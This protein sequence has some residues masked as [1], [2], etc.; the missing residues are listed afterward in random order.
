MAEAQAVATSS[1]TSEPDYRHLRETILTVLARGDFNLNCDRCFKLQEFGRRLVAKIKVD[2]ENTVATLSECMTT[3]LKILDGILKEASSLRGCAL[4]R[5]R[6]WTKFHQL[7]CTT[8]ALL[9]TEFLHKL[10]VFCTNTLLLQSVTQEIFEGRMKTF[11][12]V[13][14]SLCT[15]L[16][17]EITEDEK[18]IILY[19]CGYVPVALKRRYEKRKGESM[20]HLYSIYY[21]C[22]LVPLKTPFTTM[23]ESGL[24]L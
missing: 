24:K 21:T 15:S 22:L 5:E 12:P 6:T 9:W 10:N 17:E 7:R 16:D 23:Q 18:N 8:I 11:F 13:K 19:V 14:E 3:L 20:L 4:Q 2:D 1:S